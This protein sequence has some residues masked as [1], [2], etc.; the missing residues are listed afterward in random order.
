MSRLSPILRAALNDEEPPPMR[1]VRVT[2]LCKQC[3]K[4]FLTRC[5]RKQFCTTLCRVQHYKG[6]RADLVTLLER[7]VI[8]RI[9]RVEAAY[10]DLSMRVSELEEVV[11]A[12]SRS[13]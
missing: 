3:G 5:R 9:V 1:P 6:L 2:R 12:L 13:P 10:Q 11:K 8:E 4:K 7:L